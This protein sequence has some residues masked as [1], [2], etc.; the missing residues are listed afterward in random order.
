MNADLVVKAL[1]VPA[2]FLGLIFGWGGCEVG[3]D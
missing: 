1:G 3:T 2:L